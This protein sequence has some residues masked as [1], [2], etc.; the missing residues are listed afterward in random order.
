[1]KTYTDAHIRAVLAERV[2][3]SSYRK[4]GISKV[5]IIPQLIGGKIVTKIGRM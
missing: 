1:M 4:A 2:A 5:A 3:Q